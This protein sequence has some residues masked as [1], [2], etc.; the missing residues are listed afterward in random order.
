MTLRGLRA[1]ATAVADTIRIPAFPCRE[2]DSRLPHHSMPQSGIPDDLAHPARRNPPPAPGRPR[3]QRPRAHLRRLAR[4]RHRFRRSV[5][6]A[7]AARELDGRRR[8]RQGRRAFDRAGR[9]RARDQRREDRLRLFRRHQRRGAARRPRIRRARSPA[10]AARIRRARWCAAAGRVAVR[11]RTIR[12]TCSTTRPRSRPC[13]RSTSCCVP[14][15]R[16]CSR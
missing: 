5:F 9:R 3:Q 15:I 7:C 2:G 14:P 10:T 13:A 12:S 16:A 6:P 4:A 1:I 8:H 11:R